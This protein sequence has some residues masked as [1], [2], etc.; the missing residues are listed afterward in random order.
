[1]VSVLEFLRQSLVEG[2]RGGFRAGIVDQLRRGDESG[3]GGDCHDHA[4]VS[5]DHVREEGFGEAEVGEDVE[6]ED[7]LEGGVGGGE[8]G[9]GVGEAGVVDQDCGVPV[10][11]DDG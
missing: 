6:C 7:A 1:M 9:E 11:R 3:Q 8:D 5:G 2:Q 10:C 4:V